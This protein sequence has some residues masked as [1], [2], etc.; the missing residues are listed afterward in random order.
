MDTRSQTSDPLLGSVDVTSSWS[1][2]LLDCC[3]DC[4]VC[5]RVLC[6]PLRSITRLRHRAFGDCDVSGCFLQNLDRGLSLIIDECLAGTI[7][8]RL[9]SLFNITGEETNCTTCCCFLCALCQEEREVMMRDTEL[10]PIVQEGA[11]TT[12][13][14]A[15]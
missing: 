5:C 6:C 3:N 2:G 11:P 9:K 14:I 15:R 7:R 13:T 8:N 1:S 10:T 12:V 4:T